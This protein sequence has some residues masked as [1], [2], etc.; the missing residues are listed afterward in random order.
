M[1]LC[2]TLPY[3]LVPAVLFFIAGGAAPRAQAVKT[4]T[5]SAAAQQPASGPIDSSFLTGLRWRSIGPSRGGRS[6]AVA[7]SSKR[8]QEY[9]FG[10]TGGG[11][12]KTT[13]GGLN[14]RPVG[15]QFLR[16]SSVGAI[17]ISE[18]NPD[19]VYVGMGETQL[20]GNIIQGDGVYKRPT[21]AGRGPTQV[22][23]KRGRSAASVS[24]QRIRT[25][26]MSRRSATLT[27]RRPI[28]GSSNPPTAVRPGRASSSVM[29]RREPST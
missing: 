28:A 4:A 13:D 6:Q 21:A 10:A 26:S 2:K 23:R 8:P 25:L 7:G 29:T 3:T 22:S 15:D 18:S 27:V 20:R 11:V 17:G 1:R 19:V 12:W 14:W 24:I 9:Y 5:P 16:S